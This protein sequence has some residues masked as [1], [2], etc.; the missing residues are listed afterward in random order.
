VGQTS[1][2]R[3]REKKHVRAYKDQIDSPAWREASGSAIKVMLA[4][5]L[6]E[7]GDNNGD[8]HFSDRIGA[9]MTGLSRNTV[10]RSL[11]ELIALGFIY[12]NERGGFSRKTPHAA[13]YGFTWLAGPKGSE[14]RAPSH[15]YKKWKHPENSRAQFLTETGPISELGVETDPLTGPDIEPDEMEERLVSTIPYLSG[16]EPQTVSQGIGLAEGETE[17]RKQANSP[18]RA[19]L[20]LLR[21]SLVILIDEAGPGAQ[22][23][24]A[25]RLGIPG[26]TLSKFLNGRGLPDAYVAPLARALRAEIAA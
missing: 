5:G 24:I 15:A 7:N 26:G 17:Q 23:A 2:D 8:I 16:I 1:W 25:K 20:A 12:C 19:F 6:F 13:T 18:T 22:S 4:M 11:N 3:K 9:E 10:R 21:E 14:H